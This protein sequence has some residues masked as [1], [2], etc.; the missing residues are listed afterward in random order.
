MKTRTIAFR[1]AFVVAGLLAHAAA[2]AQSSGTD[3][4][5]GHWMTTLVCDDTQDHDKLVKGYTF[6]FN[7]DVVHGKLE[8]QY[9]P[10]DGPASVR[11][12]GTIHTDGSADINAT[13]RTGKNEYSVG[14]LDPGVV[15][16]YHMRGQFD[17]TT[18]HATRTTVR[19]CEATFAKR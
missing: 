9:G 16:G 1:T 14:R 12:Q 2:T 5:D 10:V 6:I 13:G 8:G 11:Y 18:G 3:A 7:V 15:Y 17:A 4:F 19:A